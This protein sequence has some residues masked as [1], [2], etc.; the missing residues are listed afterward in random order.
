[1]ASKERR[2]L[3]RG[4]FHLLKDLLF[5]LIRAIG[6]HATGF[7]TAFGI[8]LVVG[9]AIAAAGTW[10]FAELAGNVKEGATQ[11]FDEAVLRWMSLHRID[12]LERSLL[13]ITAL[14]TGLVVMVVVGVAALFLHYTNHKYSSFLLLFSTAGGIVLNNILKLTF[15]RERPDVFEWSTHAASSSFPSGHAMSAAVV[16]ATIAFLLARLQPRRWTRIATIGAALLLIA[17]VSMSRLYLGVHYPSDVLGGVVIG[18][19]WAGFCVA[20]LEAVRVYAKRYRK[21]KE[22]ARETDINNPPKAAE[23]TR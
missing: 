5:A 1:M 9:V 15:D 8:F 19:A 14:G 12:W 7:Y 16:Y 4:R 21:P 11:R 6:R 18:L 23:A 3:D 10:V 2:A 13:E 22:L 17:L 20:G